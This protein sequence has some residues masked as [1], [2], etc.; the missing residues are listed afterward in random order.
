MLACLLACGIDPKKSI[1]FRQSDVREHSEL[2]WL[3]S[4]F[5][6]F[7]QLRLMTQFKDKSKKSG[8]ACSAALFGYPVL[9]AADILLYRTT[10]VPVGHD[11]LQHIEL[12]REIAVSFNN[13]YVNYSPGPVFVLPQAMLAAG[14]PRVMSLRDATNKMSKSDPAVC[15]NIMSIMYV[16]F[17]CTGPRANQLA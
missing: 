10:H 1:I 16:S 8:T 13:S 12:A 4:P 15:G 17:S 2:A 6:L 9:Q 7:N 11:Q 5:A 3:L 14:L